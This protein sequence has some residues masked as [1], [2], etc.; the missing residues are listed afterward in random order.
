MGCNEIKSPKEMIEL[1]ECNKQ[2]LK[3]IQI[4]NKKDKY[5]NAEF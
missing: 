1:I 4:D 3:K 5:K 2:I